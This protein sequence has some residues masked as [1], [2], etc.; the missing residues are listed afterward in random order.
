MR[1]LV[2]YHLYK[3]RHAKGNT[4]KFPK[5]TYIL[6]RYIERGAGRPHIKYTRA[7]ASK[8]ERTELGIGKKDEAWQR[9]IRMSEEH[10]QDMTT[11]PGGEGGPRVYLLGRTLDRRVDGRRVCRIRHL[12]GNCAHSSRSPSL[13][14]SP[15]SFS[16]SLTRA[17]EVGLFHLL[18][19]SPEGRWGCEFS[20][21]PQQLH[22]DTNFFDYNLFLCNS[23]HLWSRSLVRS[24]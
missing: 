22:R 18:R 11:G 20:S 24:S 6:N 7:R 12:W 8:G 1:F 15:L 2:Q 10:R 4:I 13:F 16:L 14:L 19:E 5:H 17:S 23:C 9:E 21:A 3:S